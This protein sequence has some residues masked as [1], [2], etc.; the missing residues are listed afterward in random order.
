MRIWFNHWFSTAYHLI[1][2]MKKDFGEALT[3]VGSGSNSKAVY[4]QAC[5]E[6]Y[7]EP[8]MSTD[9]YVAFCLDFCSVHNIDVFVPRR[10]LVEISNNAD[11]F[12]QIGVKLLLE[13]NKSVISMLDDKIQT[14]AF[15]KDRIPEIIPQYCLA[16]CLNEFNQAYNELQ[17]EGI[18]LCYKLAI[19]EGAKSFRVLDDSIES[20]KALYEKPGTKVTYRA[21]REILS[22]YD[23]KIP[24]ILM[25]YMTGPDVSVDCMETEGGR[26]IIPRFKVGRFS[27]IRPD[28]EIIRICHRVMDILCFEMPANIQFKMNNDWPYLLEINP[29]MSGGL[30][31]SCMATEINVP[32][33]AL[34][35]CCGMSYEWHY[36]KQWAPRGIVNLETPIIVS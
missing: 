32:A 7:S 22:D 28:Q 17:T 36:P 18:R 23:F 2:L 35:K 34:R 16:H 14:Y 4:R 12:E 30:Q 19:D 13:K 8:E 6:W 20:I 9:C 5:D 31:L 26:I 24:I 21:A 27:E 11:S 3:V 15:F 1:K 10:S 25:E 33:I 29:R